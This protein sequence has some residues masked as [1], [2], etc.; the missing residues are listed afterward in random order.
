MWPRV[1][2]WRAFA[3]PGPTASWG[4]PAGRHDA[5]FPSLER[6]SRGPPIPRTR[7]RNGVAASA[8]TRCPTASSQGPRQALRRR[9][10]PEW[11][12]VVGARAE[13]ERGARGWQERPTSPASRGA[14]EARTR[15]IATK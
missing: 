10:P 3:A 2:C 9:V 13:G 11:T 1:M 4:D 8:G 12:V 7:S 5:G 14:A 6:R 15:F